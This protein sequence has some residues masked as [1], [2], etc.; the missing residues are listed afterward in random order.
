MVGHS[1]VELPQTLGMVLTQACLCRFRIQQCCHISMCR[2]L[3]TDNLKGVDVYGQ[4]LA[5]PTANASFSIKF[6]HLVAASTEFLF[7]IG[8]IADCAIS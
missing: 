5:D 1:C 6:D 3:S 2:F 8:T 7:Q 4:Y